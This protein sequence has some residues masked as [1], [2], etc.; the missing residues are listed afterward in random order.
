MGPIWGRGPGPPR[1]GAPSSSRVGYSIC[2]LHQPGTAKSESRNLIE[3]RPET[4]GNAPTRTPKTTPTE[5][6]PRQHLA[7]RRLT[8]SAW[9][10][11]R[12]LSIKLKEPGNR[13]PN[14]GC[15]IQGT[16]RRGPSP[17][18]APAGPTNPR[19]PQRQLSGFGQHRVRKP[20][21]L[22]KAGGYAVFWSGLGH[23]RST[24]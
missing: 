21:L 1:V 9:W 8:Y 3:V 20:F 12:H 15:K 10:I 13:G 18:L 11:E 24:T 23:E 16:I 5:N 14:S 7:Q 4:S 22:P 2:R 17:A 6:A 19:P